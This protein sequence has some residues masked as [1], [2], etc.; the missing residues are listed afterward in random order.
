M[1]IWASIAVLISIGIGSWLIPNFAEQF[2][3]RWSTVLSSVWYVV[4]FAIHRW[5]NKAKV[6]HL[7]EILGKLQQTITRLQEQQGANTRA[8]ILLGNI[9]TRIFSEAKSLRDSFATDLVIDD[10]EATKQLVADGQIK[11]RGNIEIGGTVRVTLIGLEPNLVARAFQIYRQSSNISDLDPWIHAHTGVAGGVAILRDWGYDGGSSDWTVLSPR[12]G[13]EARELAHLE[14]Q[15]TYDEVIWKARS[16]TLILAGRWYHAE[17]QL[18]SIDLGKILYGVDNEGWVATPMENLSR[19]DL[20]DL[21]SKDNAMR[22]DPKKARS[23]LYDTRQAEQAL[24]DGHTPHWPVYQH[25]V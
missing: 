15:P 4:V 1:A 11:V 24:K 25:K 12:V 13:K 22:M 9:R 17:P 10:P 21:E 18:P 20:E 19:A 23:W 14:I 8:K 3:D 5:I 7:H 2:D 16:G 6:D